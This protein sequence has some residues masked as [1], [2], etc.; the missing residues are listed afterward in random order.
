MNTSENLSKAFTSFDSFLRVTNTHH[1]ISSTKNASYLYSVPRKL[2]HGQ[3]NL[4]F[5]FDAQPWFERHLHSPGNMAGMASQSEGCTIFKISDCIIDI[6]LGMVLLEADQLRILHASHHVASQ[7]NSIICNSNRSVADYQAYVAEIIAKPIPS[8]NEHLI[9]L[10]NTKWAA[11]NYYHWLQ[12]ALPRIDIS[13]N[14]LGLPCRYLWLAPFQPQRFHLQ[15]FELADITPQLIV[16]SNRFFRI[17]NLLWPTFFNANSSSRYSFTWFETSKSLHSGPTPKKLFV[18]RSQGTAR[19]ISNMFELI[20]ILE[21]YHYTV[22][23]CG[24]LSCA[25][26]HHYFSHASHIAGA[27]GA[28]L[29]NIMFSGS[30]KILEICPSESINHCFYAI[31]NASSPHLS[32]NQYFFFPVPYSN[33]IKQFLYVNPLQLDDYLWTLESA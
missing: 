9:F 7:A 8:L 21:K 12:E 28:G 15:S 17:S 30:A 18:D 32:S 26:Q 19:S 4:S 24:L 20:P 5:P 31:S 11:H 16:T 1:L 14:R 6:H 27:H 10:L 13:K 29:T 2:V 22:I 23:D 3:V 33:I 25:E